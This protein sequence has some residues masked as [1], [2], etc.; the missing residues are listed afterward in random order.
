MAT[1]I[2]KKYIYGC[3]EP[4]P[5]SGFPAGKLRWKLRREQWG[6]ALVKTADG[7][8]EYLIEEK[9][10]KWVPAGETGRNSTTLLSSPG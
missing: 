2:G 3:P 7:I 10:G 8:R 6:K 4:L 1:I 5:A 9:D